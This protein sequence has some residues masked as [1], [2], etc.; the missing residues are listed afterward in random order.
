MRVG[1]WRGSA[2]H[3]LAVLLALL[4]ASFAFLYRFNALGGALGGF[5]N[6]EF[7]ML[8]RVDLLLAG[9]QPLRDFAD[10]ELRAV[11]PSLSYEV[12]ALVQ[13]VWG[14]NL[15]VH[16]YLT[17][18]ALALCAGIVF[19]FAR[20]LSRSWV[21]AFLAAAVVIASGAKA[22]NYTKVLTLTVA[23]VALCSSILA[24]TIAR[25]GVLAVWT[26]IAALFRHDYAMYVAIPVIV[27][28]IAREPRPWSVP[29]RRVATYVGLCVLFSLPSTI[30][31][32]YYV[33]IPRYLA[34]VLASV[35]A[36]GRRL[37]QWPVVNLE[38]PLEPDSLVA[39]NY[40]AFWAVP[41]AAALVVA[42][43]AFRC[44]TH[45]S[46]TTRRDLGFGF[47]LV[48]M[49]LLVNDYFLRANLQ[50]RFGDAA[51]PVVLLGAWVTGA[52]PAMRS[53][54]GRGLVRVGP[55]ILL[56]LMLGA[57]FKSNSLAHEFEVGGVTVSTTQTQMRFREVVQTLRTLP[58]ATWEGQ[59][60]N[61]PLGVARYLAECTAPTDRVIMGLYADEI[62]YFARRLFA[63]GQG[64]FALGFLRS[65][66]DQRL[67][68]ERLARQSVPVAI[69]A[70]DYNAEI[71]SNYP[72][73]ARHIA[74]R[75][76]EVGV[77]Q[78]NGQPYVRVF[79]ESARQQRGADPVL[80]FP[81][82][83]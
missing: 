36:E 3:V 47:A 6:D 71:A 67:V 79:V 13:R 21:C 45:A 26:V 78:S 69:T 70:I 9:E 20:H 25:L 35:R 17:L 60:T 24:P 32:G 54:I 38:T 44:R 72:L 77:V 52:A 74:E 37:E 40:Y 83:R 34:D 14:R 56:A 46:P 48:A 2:G 33:G 22:Y 4:L 59:N 53:W 8:T 65:E 16:A 15:L 23:A 28:L 29:V 81:C 43:C 10:G 63:G 31:V 51:V 68:L 11:W 5:D 49:T 41:L 42:W 66:A 73:V 50:A 75:Y 58:P 76:R 1:K 18:G 30:W 55:S 27:G 57:F 19:V 61:G 64:Y 80:G 62:P 12:P 39:F 7:Q 82:F